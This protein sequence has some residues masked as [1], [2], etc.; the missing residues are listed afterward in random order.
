MILQPRPPVQDELAPFLPVDSVSEIYAEISASTELEEVFNSLVLASIEEALIETGWSEE[1]F[2][3][4]NP[5][6]RPSLTEEELRF[7]ESEL[8]EDNKIEDRGG[9]I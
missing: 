1:T 5:L 3:I 7:I 8:K 9:K 4:K 6:D 2:F